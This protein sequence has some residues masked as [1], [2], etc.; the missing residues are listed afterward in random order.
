VTGYSLRSFSE[1]N[2]QIFRNRANEGK[3]IT[4]RILIVNPK[5]AAST[6]MEKAENLSPGQY[7]AALEA[8][9]RKLQQVDGIS[10]RLIDRHL[11]MMI[12]RIDEV[13]YTGPYPHTGGSSIALTFKLGQGWIFARQLEDFEALWKEATP[14]NQGVT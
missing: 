13:M 1:Q 2:E 14:V 3:P 6:L 12:Y 10:I 8:L 11:S 4:A 9:V 5:S 7:Q